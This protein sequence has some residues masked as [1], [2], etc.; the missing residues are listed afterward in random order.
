MLPSPHDFLAHSPAVPKPSRLS[1]DAPKSD[2][3][4]PSP[5]ISAPNLPPNWLAP[6][7]SASRGGCENP[8]PSLASCPLLGVAQVFILPCHPG[9]ALSAHPCLRAAPHMPWAWRSPIVPTYCPLGEE[10]GC[11]VQLSTCIKNRTLYTAG[12]Q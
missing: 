11:L 4:F 3:F 8:K 2:L 1:L 6:L 10:L 7:L 12:V 5:T 9:L